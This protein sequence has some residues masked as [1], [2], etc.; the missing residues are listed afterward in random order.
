MNPSDLTFHT[1]KELI[2][3]LMRRKTF[4]GVVVHSKDELKSDQWD[5]ARVFQVHYNSNIESDEVHRI[6]ARVADS[7]ADCEDA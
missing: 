4:L 7:L 3:E 1:T 5:G 2:D 6:L